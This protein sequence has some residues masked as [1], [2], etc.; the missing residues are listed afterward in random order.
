MRFFSDCTGSSREFLFRV[1]L[2]SL[3]YAGV[4]ECQAEAGLRSETLC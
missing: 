3:F 4:I 2:T 1:P